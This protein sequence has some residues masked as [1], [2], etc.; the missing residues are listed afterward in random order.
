[1]FDKMSDMDD[2]MY[3]EEDYGLVRFG[4][5]HILFHFI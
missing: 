5:N 2:D 1:M 3:E 4:N